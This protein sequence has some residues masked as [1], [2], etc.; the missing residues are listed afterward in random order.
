MKNDVVDEAG[1]V[2]HFADYVV[3]LVNVVA[4]FIECLERNSVRAGDGVECLLHFLN[5]AVTLASKL[6]RVEGKRR[7]FTGRFAGRRHHSPDLGHGR[8]HLR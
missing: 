4:K 8:R 7:G 1:L 5:G 2:H 6:P 3:D